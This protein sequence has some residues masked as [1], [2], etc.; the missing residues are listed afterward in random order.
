MQFMENLLLHYLAAW[1]PIGYVIL[2]VGMMLE[3]DTVL[4]IAAYLTHAGYFALVPMLLTALWGMLLG[5]NLWYSLGLHLR[6]SEMLDFISRWAEHLAKPFDGHLRDN[7]FRTVFISKFTYGFN[8]AIITRAGM[9]NLKWKK[10]EESDIL[11][12]LLWMAIVAGLGYFSGASLSYFHNYIQLGEFSILAAIVILF[13]F[14]RVVTQLF[15]ER[16]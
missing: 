10:I 3:G 13:V 7:T 4:F 14:E 16:L 5:D 12:T 11:A 9:L 2:F 8:R 6:N 15:K 1:Q